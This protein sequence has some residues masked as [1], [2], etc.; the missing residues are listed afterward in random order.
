MRVGAGL[1][2]SVA[3]VA[4]PIATQGL[5]KVSGGEGWT[6]MGLTVRAR[7][8]STADRSPI[9]LIGSSGTRAHA[10]A[11]QGAVVRRDHECDREL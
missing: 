7:F 9:A 5:A 8:I 2:A 6:G 1:I 10:S 4:G 3:L 11:K